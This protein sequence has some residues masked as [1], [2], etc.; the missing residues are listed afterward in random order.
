M[1]RSWCVF[2][3]NNPLKIFFNALVSGQIS[4]V[5]FITLCPSH[6]ELRY[7]FVALPTLAGK[8]GVCQ[9]WGKS[10]RP[11]FNCGETTPISAY[12]RNSALAETRGGVAPTTLTRGV[13]TQKWC[14][15]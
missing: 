12:G 6:Y 13:T 3:F 14:D 5:L 4:N 9:I 7:E 11:Q 10:V 8:S 15:A 1:G 2:V